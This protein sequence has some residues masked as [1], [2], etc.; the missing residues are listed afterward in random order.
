[1]AGSSCGESAAVKL[2]SSSLSIVITGSSTLSIVITGSQL[3]GGGRELALVDAAERE[4]LVAGDECELV[5]E[6]WGRR[7]GEG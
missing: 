5:G 7:W 6:D 3:G 2:P 4:E 1:M